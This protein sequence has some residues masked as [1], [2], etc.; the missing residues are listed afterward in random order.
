MK[1]LTLPKNLSK[2]LRI[3]IEYWLGLC[4]DLGRIPK[5]SE[6]ELMDIWPVAP[7]LFI[8]DLNSN[9]DGSP[10]YRWRYWGTALRDYTGIEGTGKFLHQTHDPEAVDDAL[11][12]YNK[13]LETSEPDHWIKHM[14]I[15]GIDGSHRVYERI[16]VPLLNDEEKP[17]HILGVFVAGAEIQPLFETGGNLENGRMSFARSNDDAD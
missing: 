14:R 10:D 16:I 7:F 4:K 13:V 1:V 2:E 3:V 5:L 6:I 12:S 11:Q 9:D 15:V 8:A 17:A